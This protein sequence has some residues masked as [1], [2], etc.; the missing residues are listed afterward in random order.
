MAAAIAA[1]VSAVTIIAAVGFFVLGAALPV[2][3]RKKANTAIMR[4]SYLV[5][6]IVFEFVLCSIDV[7]EK[8]GI[9]R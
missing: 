9:K 2:I 5:T 7:W 1:G 8:F 4:R 6:A 3:S